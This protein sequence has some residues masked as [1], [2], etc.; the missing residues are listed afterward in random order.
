MVAPEN[1]PGKNCPQ[2]WKHNSYSNH[3]FSGSF[4]Y[5]VPHIPCQC[6]RAG[7][8]L[9]HH[10]QRPQFWG[11]FASDVCWL[12]EKKAF[13]M[14]MFG[15]IEKKYGL[16][17]FVCWWF[18]ISVVFYC[19][20]HTASRRVTVQKFEEFHEFWNDMVQWQSRFGVKSCRISLGR[21]WGIPQS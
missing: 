7:G 17:C 12:G 4:R 13:T 5:L 6:H 10:I 3:P 20:C 15:K 9:V 21:F 8:A 18:Q 1:R 14:N 16:S 11:F 2:F 19:P